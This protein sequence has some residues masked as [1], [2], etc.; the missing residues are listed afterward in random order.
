MYLGLLTRLTNLEMR[1][2]LIR[3]PPAN[4]VAQGMR[5]VLEYLGEVFKTTQIVE[6][7]RLMLVGKEN[8]GYVIISKYI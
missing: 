3:D 6:R 1:W 7:Y 5:S 8:V 4:V 2:E